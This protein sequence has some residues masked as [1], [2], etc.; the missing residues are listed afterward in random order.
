M[1]LGTQHGDD[2]VRASGDVNPESGQRRWQKNRGDQG[3]SSVLIRTDVASGSETP[4]PLPE[5][6]TATPHKYTTAT[7]PRATDPSARDDDVTPRPGG[8]WLRTSRRQRDAEPR[9]SPR[10][11]CGLRC[12]MAAGPGGAVP[13]QPEPALGPE[14]WPGVPAR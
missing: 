10:E 7:P 4:K 13:R 5:V 1:W 11:S 8:D 9:L 6:Q 12:G 14:T 2:N 3:V